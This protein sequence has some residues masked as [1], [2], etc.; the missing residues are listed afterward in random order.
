MPHN[1]CIIVP[2]CCLRTIV[3]RISADETRPVE[4][5]FSQQKCPT[6]FRRA[7]IWND[8]NNSLK[9]M[10]FQASAPQSEASEEYT[11]VFLGIERILH[12]SRQFPLD[13]WRI[14]FGVIKFCPLN[15]EPPS[16][17]GL[18]RS[19]LKAQTGVRIPLGAQNNYV[20]EFW[21]GSMV[22]LSQ[23]SKE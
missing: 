2:P 9:R 4:L 10:P 5:S 16:S 1:A 22:L 15:W 3:H 17:S 13:C 6:H 21:E 7:I 12:K 23:N 20:M 19:P 14:P 18:G 8:Q 11:T